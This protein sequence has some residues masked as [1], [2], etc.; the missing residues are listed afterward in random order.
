MFWDAARTAI[1]SALTALWCSKNTNLRIS[2]HH[3]STLQVKETTG[4]KTQGD[5]QAHGTHTLL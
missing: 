3:P 2:L 5:L 1:G 4:M